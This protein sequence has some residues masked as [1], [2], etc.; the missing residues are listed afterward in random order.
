MTTPTAL[1]AAARLAGTF[2][3]ISGWLTLSPRSSRKNGGPECPG[4][5]GGYSPD[6][7]LGDRPVFGPFFGGGRPPWRPRPKVG[8]VLAC[9]LS[10]APA[11]LLGSLPVC[12]GSAGPLGDTWAF[13][14]RLLLLLLLNERVLDLER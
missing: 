2:L 14:I 4:R 13:I 7:R 10:P 5:A 1:H 3:R 12:W 6:F 9:L 8:L 11:T